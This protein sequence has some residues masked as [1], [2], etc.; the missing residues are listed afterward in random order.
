MTGTHVYDV[1]YIV[2]SRGHLVGS[3]EEFSFEDPR[4]LNRLFALVSHGDILRC[5]IDCMIVETFV[6]RMHRNDAWPSAY[7][8]DSGA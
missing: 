3:I 5:F 1:V 2:D 8:V 7:R 4:L 6:I